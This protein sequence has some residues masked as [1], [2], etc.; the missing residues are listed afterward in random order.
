MCAFQVTVTIVNVND[1]TISGFENT[2]QLSTMGGDV[3][4]LVGTNFGPVD[5]AVPATF[6]VTYGPSGG[7]YIATGCTRLPGWANTRLQC[8]SSPGGGP[9]LRWRVSVTSAGIPGDVVL[10][11][12]TTTYLPPL[13]LGLS[14]NAASLRTAVRVAA[15]GCPACACVWCV[16]G[17]CGV[18]G[19]CV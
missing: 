1:V 14:P 11:D 18:C 7:P 3:V 5:L 19:V 17:V 12:V 2:T 16:C 10:S 15:R 9:G 6:L 4:T 13:I 8:T